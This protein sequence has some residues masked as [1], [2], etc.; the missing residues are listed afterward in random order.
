M[1]SSVTN[2][3]VTTGY[4]WS[5]S[6]TIRTLTVTD[7]ASHTSTIVSNTGTSRINSITDQLGHTTSFTYDG[8]SRLTR[9][10]Q[11][12][13]NYVNYTLD[14]RGNV[15]ETRHVAK[16]GS[17]LSDI[18]ETAGYP[19][20]CANPVTC[21]EPTSTTDARGYT[22][23]YT[24]DSTH[25]GVLTITAPAPSGTGDRPQTR[26]SYTNTTG[27]Y[28]LTGI[29]SCASGASPACVGTA[30]ESR[31][32][33][34]YDAS[35][36]MTSVQRRDGTGALSATTTMTY[37]GVGNMIMADGPLSGTADTTRYRY[38]AGR[39]LVGVVGP[40]PDDT[41]TLKHRAVRT[42]WTNGL[43]TRVE[44]GT[45]NSQSDADWAAF[46]SLEQ[47]DTAYD[48][49]ARP[50]TQALSS[51]GTT[52]ALT[53]TSYDSLGRVSCTAQRMNPAIYGALPSSA[54]TLGTA[55]TF[56]PDRITRTT[57]DN[58]GQVALVQTGYGVTGVQADEIASTWTNNGRQATVTDANGNR[59]TYVYDGFDRLSRT[60]MPSPTTPG[61]SS[62]TDY[63]E[64]GYDAASNVTSRRLR[65]GTSIAFTYDHLNRPTLKNLPGSELDVSYT[66]DLTGHLLTAST[67][68]QTLT[69]TWDAVGRNLT[70]VGPLGAATSAY[71]P[72]GRRTQLTYPGTGLYVNYDYDSVGDLTKVRENGASTGVGVLATWAYDD[73]G[74]RTTLTRGN[75]T[76]TSY[77][78][79][80]VSRLSSLTQDLASTGNDLTLGFSYN[81]ASHITNTTRSNDAYAYGDLAN[82]ATA[83]SVNGLNQLTAIGGQSVTHDSRGNVSAIGSSGYGYSSENLLTSAPGSATL[84]YDPALRLYQTV[85]G[86]VTTRFAYDGDNMI[87][88]YNGSSALQRRYVFDPASGDP[89]VWYEGTGTSTR[90]WFHADERGSVVAVSD[91]SGN[92][93]GS[94]NAYDEYGNPQGGSI[95]GRFGYTGQAWI[96][97]ANLWYYR[98]RMY[99][100]SLGRFMQTDPIG[101]GGGMNIYAYVFNDPANLTDPSGLGNC[102][103]NYSIEYEDKNNNHRRDPGE[104]SFPDSLMETGRVCLSHQ[105]SLFWGGGGAGGGGAV[106]SSQN[107]NTGE[108]CEARLTSLIG[109]AR[110]VL[111]TTQDGVDV[112]TIVNAAIG[113]EPGA[114]G[115]TVLN[116]FLETQLGLVNLSD[117]LNS[118]DWGPLV[119]QGLALPIRLL[120]AGRSLQNVLVR[121]RL[122]G[123]VLR[124][125]RGRFRST[126]L[127]NAAVREAGQQAAEHGGQSI[128][129][130]VI[131]GG[132]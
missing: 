68:A 19:S 5:T 38:D 29:S 114:L 65:D 130:A 91:T 112:A 87:A 2:E 44:R 128:L 116:D 23:D 27:E 43:A 72:A 53:Q 14:A 126:R 86:G 15:T 40:D 74:R 34:G 30:A 110:A 129:S 66:Y 56:G 16:S 18:V 51:G 121:F 55:G 32:V 127:R 4:G 125:I 106:S 118:G 11:P 12:E 61:T 50:V 119:V 92:L 83:S 120:P 80:A 105:P 108:N 113:D 109:S 98:A 49:N 36:N 132:H 90:R 17:G 62:T 69:F 93:V 96:P 57:Y 64:L 25:G 97:E 102:L 85:G 89:L 48:A 84:A 95:I 104:P 7:A 60:R 8:S 59:T 82:G 10:T 70:Q 131:C 1:V 78:Y 81:P 75:G 115:L 122:D 107:G 77:G 99:N 26:Y 37:D 35:G 63:E 39:R 13:G 9:V 88:E 67:S 101:F 58:A 76:T 73:L 100:P 47:V 46:S 20:T 6:G 22:T 31:V 41:G 21:N 94:R 103:Y 42:T 45:V 54:C 52:Y 117:G 123:G 3:G 28:F 79:D 111:E 71:D 33:I 124:D 24:Y